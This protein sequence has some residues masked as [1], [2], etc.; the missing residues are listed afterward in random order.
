MVIRVQKD[1]SDSEDKIQGFLPV[2]F[3]KL[4]NWEPRKRVMRNE[5]VGEEDS[6]SFRGKHPVH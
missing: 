1:F 3:S 5:D 4:E 6:S 2:D